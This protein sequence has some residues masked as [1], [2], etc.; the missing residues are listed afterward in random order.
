MTCSVCLFIRYRAARYRFSYPRPAH[1][2]HSCQLQ[3]LL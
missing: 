1:C 2:R 3:R